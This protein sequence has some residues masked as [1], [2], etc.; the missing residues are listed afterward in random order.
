MKQ[1]LLIGAGTL[2]IAGLAASTHAAILVDYDD[3]TP[4]GGHDATV[5]SGDFGSTEGDF[6]TSPWVN[7]GGTGPQT[8]INL[9][10]GVGT[11]ANVVINDG[12]LYGVDTEHTIAAGDQ[13]NLSFMWR[14]AF[15]WDATDDTVELVLYYTD[16]NAIGGGILDSII[17]NSGNRETLET[18]E[19]ESASLQSFSDDSGAGK[20]LFVQIRTTDAES[21]EFS[22]VDNVFVEVVPE[23][24]SLALLGLGGLLIARRRRA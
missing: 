19:N 7:L 22:R 17:L 24:G 4:G 1:N 13:Y 20:T 10:S 9:Q 23:P 14:D 21:S 5:R 6:V 8:R 16:T 3:G 2:L 12:R 18:W 15:Q 11:D